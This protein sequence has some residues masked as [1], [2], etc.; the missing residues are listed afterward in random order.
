MLAHA[1]R[2]VENDLEMLRCPYLIYLLTTYQELMTDSMVAIG[3]ISSN[4]TEEGV[5]AL[6]DSSSPGPDGASSLLIK[7]LPTLL[8]KS[9]NALNTRT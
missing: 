9:F 2:S 6:K 8:P 3:E 7:H 5:T 1:S 4:E